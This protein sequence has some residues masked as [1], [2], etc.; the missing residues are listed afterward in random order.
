MIIR[1]FLIERCPQQPAGS[2]I[3]EFLHQLQSPKARG[4]A[5][6][7]IGDWTLD[8]DR[9]WIFLV[10]QKE[11]HFGCQSN[12]RGAISSQRRAATVP[13]Q[14]SRRTA[15][16]NLAIQNECDASRVENSAWASSGCKR[17]ASRRGYPSLVEGA[18]TGSDGR[19]LRGDGSRGVALA[20]ASAY[21][22]WWRLLAK[23][24]G[25]GA[26]IDDDK[27]P[28]LTHWLIGG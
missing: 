27:P 6:L 14:R 11:H 25:L 7:L 20:R 1:R 15:K 28:K 23:R 13:A 4:R 10:S 21:W 9:G 18:I 26:F 12:G 5:E 17:T 19:R 22:R 8:S 24:C 16:A 2:A 3:D